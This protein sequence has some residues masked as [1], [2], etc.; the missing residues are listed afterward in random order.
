MQIQCEASVWCSCKTWSLTCMLLLFPLLPHSVPLSSVTR[1]TDDLPCISPLTQRIQSNRTKQT[2]TDWTLQNRNHDPNEPLLSQ[3]DCL[4][5]GTESCFTVCTCPTHIHVIPL[6][7]QTRPQAYPYLRGQIV[8]IVCF[9]PE[10]YYS[11]ELRFSTYQGVCLP[12][13]QPCHL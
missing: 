13:S 7:E 8:K 1:R 2:F 10:F 4:G 5:P 3:A 6:G 12:A 11:D 9:V